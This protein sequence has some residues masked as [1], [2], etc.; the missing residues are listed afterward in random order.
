[1][2]DRWLVLAGIVG[3]VLVLGWLI[4]W[5]YRAKLLEREERRLMIERGMTP[6]PPQPTGW[7]AVRAREQELRYQERQLLIEKGLE[8]GDPDVAR[9]LVQ[10][11][12][13]KATRGPES[14]LHRGLVT[15]AIGL[16]LLAPY[17][18]L[19]WSGALVSDDSRD[20]TLFLAVLG[21]LVALYGTANLLYYALTKNRPSD[22][23]SPSSQ[24]SRSGS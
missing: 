4:Y 9:P 8:P 5:V 3:A 19:R 10:F 24:D 18:I 1:M 12:T 20:F 13:Q 2:T 14:T 15:L 17:A 16:G 7:P 11:L 23:A 22:A 21:P 6:P